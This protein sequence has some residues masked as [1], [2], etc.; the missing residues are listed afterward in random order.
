ME[1]HTSREIDPVTGVATTGHSWDGIRELN[2]PLPRWWLWLFYATILWS[3]G[4]W[5][6]YPSWPLISSYTAGILGWQ[7]RA[8]VRADLDELRALRGAMAERLA[9]T[10]LDQVADD[11]ELL[12]FALAQGR[13][14]FGDNCAPCHGAGG[15]GGKGFPNLNDDDWLFG[16]R[17]ADISQTLHHG[18]RW[19]ADPGTRVGDMPAFGRD[20]MLPRADIVD[21]AEFVRSLAGLST[22]PTVDLAHGAEVF[23]DNCAACHADD[24]KGNRELGAPNLTDAV[25]LYGS[26]AD[27]IVQG[28]WGGHGAVMPAW[29]GRLDESTIKALTVYVHSF[30]GGE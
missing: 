29:G 3:I 1:P 20:G 19:T 24:G 28:I 13:A 25:W 22:H 12:A 5:I 15:G 18:I 2:N 8:A 10:P 27:A 16:G 9:G 4:Y 26:D 17:L 21:V 7:S 23:T 11:S 14:S 6:L 30:G